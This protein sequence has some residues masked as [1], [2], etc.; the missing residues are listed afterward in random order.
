MVNLAVEKAREA[1]AEAECM[2]EILRRV[3]RYKK[4]PS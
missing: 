3:E 4:A 1:H 2:A